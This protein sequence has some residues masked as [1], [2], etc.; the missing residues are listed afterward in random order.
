[1]VLIG[2]IIASMSFPIMVF[3]NVMLV[4]VVSGRPFVRLYILN[5]R[6]VKL[7]FDNV[8]HTRLGM[9]TMDMLRMDYHWGIVALYSH[10]TVTQKVG[11]RPYQRPQKQGL[12]HV[13]L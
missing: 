3:V 11:H 2:V 7:L 6:I 12:K 5:C 10:T 1:M 9:N 13:D 8:F 4:A